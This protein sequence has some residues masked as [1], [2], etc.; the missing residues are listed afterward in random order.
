MKKLPALI[1]CAALSL[2]VLCAC[3]AQPEAST[4]APESVPP[5]PELSAAGA[6]FRAVDCARRGEGHYTR[7]E[8]VNIFYSALI[9]GDKGKEYPLRFTDIGDSGV[10]NAAA[11]LDHYGLLDFIEGEKLLPARELRRV[12]AERLLQS[13]MPGVRLSAEGDPDAPITGSELAAAWQEIYDELTDG[14]TPAP[15][16]TPGPAAASAPEPLPEGF[17]FPETDFEPQ[18]CWV[19]EP[20]GDGG[21]ALLLMGG[22]TPDSPLE[23]WY[24]S[25]VETDLEVY[26]ERDLA[27]LNLAAEKG[28]ELRVRGDPSFPIALAMDGDTL[29]L[30]P[31]E[32]WP[33]H[34]LPERFERVTREEALLAWAEMPFCGEVSL[35]VGACE[36][37]E[38]LLA[39]PGAGITSMG[40]YY[41]TYT[42]PGCSFSYAS[43]ALEVFTATE[44]YTGLSIRGLDVGCTLGD[45]LASFPNALGPGELGVLY[46]SE[47]YNSARGALYEGEEDL[48]VYLLIPGSVHVFFYL[49]SS[50]TVES[51]TVSYFL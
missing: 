11:Y 27:C 46:G 2:S 39:I 18:S 16:P 51:I 31:P 38:A 13:L 26:M 43:R 14:E 6:L 17:C 30:E 45:I 33:F 4:A 3:G 47:E 37:R 7:S 10:A 15:L 24:S 22:D 5:L 20:F 50:D 35:P 1:L 44:P 23:L 42:A 25:W 21:Q 34:P 32:D 41:T 29:T 12:E 28:S 19:A 49:D 9:A 36:D 48:F 8:A 40:S